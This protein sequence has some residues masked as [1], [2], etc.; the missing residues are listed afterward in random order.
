MSRIHATG[1]G[2]CISGELRTFFAP[3]VGAQIRDNLLLPLQL[4]THIFMNMRTRADDTE[5]RVRRVLKGVDL[6]ALQVERSFADRPA[7]R[8]KSYAL[9]RGLAKCFHSVRSDDRVR[10]TWIVRLRSDHMI[11]FRLHTLP[12]ASCYYSAH[13]WASGIAL[14]ASLANCSCGWTKRAC[15][16][17]RASCDW[18][19]DQFALLHGSAVEAYFQ[20]FRARFCDHKYIG[21]SS[22]NDIRLLAP[23]RRLARMFSSRNVTVHDMRF[24]GGATHPRLQRTPNCDKPGDGRL[25]LRTY[26]VFDI[27]PH[28]MKKVLPTGPW[29]QRREEVC[30]YQRQLPSHKR[31]WCLHYG[32]STDD[33]RQDWRHHYNR[34]K[35]NI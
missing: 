9:S 10:Y 27:P 17:E 34:L 7:C 19:D 12:C 2:A 33:V 13:P 20:D 29:D 8:G 18:V 5:G 1:P 23:E 30:R 4:R 16:T 24:M 25:P 35:R 11:P 28:S 26:P 6:A 15:A 14:S 31:Y 21:L 3:C 32:P 22:P